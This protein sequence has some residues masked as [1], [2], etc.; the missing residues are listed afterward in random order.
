[1]LCTI[2]NACEQR[3]VGH[4]PLPP[5]PYV[6]DMRYQG[7]EQFAVR[8][9]GTSIDKKIPDGFFAICVK[10]FEARRE[11]T[12]GDFVVVQRKRDGLYEGT[13]KQLVKGNNGWELW[14]RSNDP[15]HQIP[16]FL[17]G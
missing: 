11:P 2:L 17:Q 7:L 5:V 4:D 9:A 3:V 14:P 12:D 8:V 10:Y 16:C 15:C 6:N 1:M 13:I